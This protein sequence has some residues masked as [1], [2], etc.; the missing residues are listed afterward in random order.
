M[1]FARWSEPLADLAEVWLIRPGRESRISDPAHHAMGALI[2][3]SSTR[4]R[5]SGR[6]ARR[7]PSSDTAW[8]R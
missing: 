2:L 3:N 4:S 6:M 7:P 1:P 8:A 5:R